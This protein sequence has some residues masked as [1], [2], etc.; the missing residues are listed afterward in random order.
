MAN[1]TIDINISSGKQTKEDKVFAGQDSKQE[2][3]EEVSDTSKS[4][5]TFVATQAVKPF[6][7]SAINFATSNVQL[8]TGSSGL[9]EQVNFAMQA[10]NDATSIVGM[11]SAGAVLGGGPIG[12]LV[13]FTIGVAQKGIDIVFNQLQ[14]DVNM[15]NENKQIS[16]I[17][18]RLGASFN[19][20]RRG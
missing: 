16:Y 4:L 2:P 15:N 11:T 12:A 8:V 17:Q 1:Y 3:K 5:G 6:L 18:D 13:G 14:K 20:S 9:Q 7:R 10:V 19:N